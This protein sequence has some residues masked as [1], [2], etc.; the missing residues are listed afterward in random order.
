MTFKFKN[1]IYKI[2]DNQTDFL[3]LE[4]LNKQELNKVINALKFNHSL[5]IIELNHCEITDLSSLCKNLKNNY[6]LEKLYLRFNKIKDITPLKVLENKSCLEE[7]DLSYNEIDD[8][9]PL[10]FL[11]N[12]SCLKRLYLSRNKIKDLT[13]LFKFLEKINCLQYL[14]I[15]FNN[16]SI[17]DFLKLRKLTEFKQIK[18]EID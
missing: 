17:E 6:C 1:T 16:I 7:L 3:Y 8:L 15:Y 18:I 9:T 14:Y 11:E 12:N 13:P 2:I 10:Q 5:K 4:Y